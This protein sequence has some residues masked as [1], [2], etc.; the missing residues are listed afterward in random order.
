MCVRTVHIAQWLELPLG[1]REAGVRSPTMSHRRCNRHNNLSM[2]LLLQFLIPIADVKQNANIHGPLVLMLNPYV[3]TSNF[4]NYCHIWY[5]KKTERTF[6]DTID[7]NFQE[8]FQ[9]SH[10]R[11]VRE[12]SFWIG[13]TAPSRETHIINSCWWLICW[14]L[15]IS[16]S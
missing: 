15:I 6:E 10:F 13:T 1:V 2:D 11:Y 9:S 14:W 16:R 3:K 5:F 4:F 12:H 7:K 8:K